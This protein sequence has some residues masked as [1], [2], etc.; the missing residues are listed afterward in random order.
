MN[1]LI[2]DHCAPSAFQFTTMP[3]QTAREFRDLGRKAEDIK[4]DL[5]EHNL[6][7]KNTVSAVVVACSSGVDIEVFK[8]G[9]T[10]HLASKEECKD[11]MPST[12][13]ER[14]QE[15]EEEI[16]Y[17]HCCTVVYVLCSLLVFQNVQWI[18]SVAILAQAFCFA[19]SALS[20]LS[21]QQATSKT[22]R[23]Q[24]EKDQ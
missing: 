23:L 21:V 2:L 15:E 10:P 12:T 5:P 17:M 9:E 4:R 3:Q 1:C 6:E 11:V 24:P 13:S 22:W 16:V 14:T 7:P 19:V 18:C 20:Y 8:A